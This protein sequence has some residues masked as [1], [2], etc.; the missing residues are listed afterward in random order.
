MY[1]SDCPLLVNGFT[2]IELMEIKESYRV[3]PLDCLLLVP[4][5][6]YIQ[7]GFLALER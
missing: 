3:L 7:L 5:F 2:Y 6:T 1:I 4:I